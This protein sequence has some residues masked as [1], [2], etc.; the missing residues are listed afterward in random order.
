MRATCRMGAIAVFAYATLA[1]VS[2]VCLIYFKVAPWLL[3]IGMKRYFVLEHFGAFALLGVVFCFAYPK[4]LLMICFIVFGSAI[5][6]ELMQT[7]TPDR[8]AT[9]L[10]VIE[11]LAD[12][13]CGIFVARTMLNWRRPSVRMDA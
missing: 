5:A 3:D 4:R 11:K 8:H 6:L 2:L 12:G 9:I 10:D 1:H 13:A 7:L